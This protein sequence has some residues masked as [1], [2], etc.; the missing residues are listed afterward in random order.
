MSPWNTTAVWS[1]QIA[2][3]HATARSVM[4]PEKPDWECTEF[5]NRAEDTCLLWQSGLLFLFGCF[6]GHSAVGYQHVFTVRQ[7]ECDDLNKVAV[8]SQHS[9][10]LFSGQLWLLWR[11]FW[12]TGT[13]TLRHISGVGST[14][15]L[16]AVASCH[17]QK[18]FLQIV[19]GE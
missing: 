7:G 14:S 16:C 11:F 6:P 18:W 8:I 2:A 13:N 19:F 1:C 9:S 12:V 3:G 5:Q 15:I 10:V 4:N 17:H